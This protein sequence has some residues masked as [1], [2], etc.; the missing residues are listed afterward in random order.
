MGGMQNREPY[1]YIVI[2]KMFFTTI[3]PNFKTPKG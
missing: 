2:G 1:M 3:M